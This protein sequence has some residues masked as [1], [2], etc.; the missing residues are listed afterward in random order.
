MSDYGDKKMDFVVENLVSGYFGNAVLKDITFKLTEPAI[1]VVLGPNGAG[2]TTLLRSMAGI[3]KPMQGK[4]ELNGLPV[5]EQRSRRR[6]SYL[7]HLDGIPEGLTVIEALKFY[8]KIEGAGENSVSNVAGKLE[9]NELLSKRF[10]QLSQGQKKRVSVA[11]I[12]LQERDIYL[13]DEPTSNLDPKIAGG[14]RSLILG[15]SKNKI[16]LYSSHN[17]YEAKEIGS[18]VIAIKGGKLAL[19]SK[20]NELKPQS[21]LIGIRTIGN[22]APMAFTRKEGDYYIYELSYPEE[23]QELISKLMLDGIKLREVREMSNPLEDL[24]KDH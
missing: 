17:L 16:V 9:L 20:I 7:S 5:N 8:A 24:F 14:I 23:V 2:K 1:Y 3:L 12:F 4:V 13:L 10:S 18:Y 19:F 22:T 6:L 11:R 15:M 21:Y